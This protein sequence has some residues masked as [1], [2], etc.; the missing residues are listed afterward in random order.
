MTLVN[1]M[2]S[3][4]VSNAAYVAPYTSLVTSSMMGK[5]RLMK[6]IASRCPTIYICLRHGK[7]TFQYPN[8]TPSVADFLL[9]GVTECLPSD[10]P[11]EEQ[12]NL[13]STLKFSAFI[14]ATLKELTEWI[15]NKNFAKAVGKADDQV[16]QHEWLWQFFAEPRREVVLREFWEAVIAKTKSIIHEAANVEGKYGKCSV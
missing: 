16:F 8:R 14:E 2:E 4:S 3:Y 15:T 1:Y 12:D 5:T 6:E 7:A 11:I 9:D 13:I 10:L